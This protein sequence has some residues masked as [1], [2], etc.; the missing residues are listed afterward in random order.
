VN[1]AELV[2]AGTVTEAGTVSAL[3]LFDANVTTLPLAGA[4]WVRLTVHVVAAPDV[5]LVGLQ[6][7]EDT[8]GL[9]ATV[10]VAVVF[11]PSAAVRVNV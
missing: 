2:L 10:T 7:T 8:L 5:R 6:T 3:M 11:P 1:A 4:I 9:G